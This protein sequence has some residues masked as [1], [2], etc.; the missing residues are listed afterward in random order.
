MI[1]NAKHL[2]VSSICAEY[3]PLNGATVGYCVR[4]SLHMTLNDCVGLDACLG[5]P[6]TPVAVD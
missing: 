2:S 1:R 5:I 6:G 4:P 3:I